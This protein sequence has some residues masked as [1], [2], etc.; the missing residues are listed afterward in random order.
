LKE[1]RRKRN[2]VHPISLF[3]EINKF[4]ETKEAYFGVRTLNLKQDSSEKTDSANNL[5]DIERSRRIIKNIGNI[6]EKT[7]HRKEF[8]DDL[9]NLLNSFSPHIQSETEDPS[10]FKLK[11]I[12]NH[13]FKDRINLFSKD[14]NETN[15]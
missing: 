11:K 1:A 4:P 2:E 10:D 3:V 9:E 12:R 6:F 5:A 7:A 8:L 15:I 13:K 14:K